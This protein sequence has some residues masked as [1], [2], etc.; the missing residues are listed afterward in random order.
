MKTTASSLARATALCAFMLGWPMLGWPCD[1][2]WGP[3][4]VM[5]LAACYLPAVEERRDRLAWRLFL[6]LAILALISRNLL[7]SGREILFLTPI[8]A[9]AGPI[10]GRA[11]ADAAPETRRL[12]FDAVGIGIRGALAGLLAVG[13]HLWVMPVPAHGSLLGHVMQSAAA[14]AFAFYNTSCAVAHRLADKTHL[15]P[16]SRYWKTVNIGYA[17][18]FG[19]GIVAEVWV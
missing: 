7:D 12:L 11:A 8:I 4:V 10:A 15:R 17:A 9:L 19:I 16:F 3:F 18:L 1:G 6:P 5:F 2:T 14:F 13:L